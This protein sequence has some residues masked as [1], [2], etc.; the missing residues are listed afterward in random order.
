MIDLLT[1][2][3]RMMPRMRGTEATMNIRRLNFEDVADFVAHGADI[4][5]PKPQ[6]LRYRDVQSP[7]S[8]IQKG[9]AKLWR[10]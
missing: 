7:A 6:A 10:S 4:V 3:Q 1:M 5:H 9:Q 2:L 8:G